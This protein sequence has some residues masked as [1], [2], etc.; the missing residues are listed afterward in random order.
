MTLHWPSKTSTF[1]CLFTT[2]RWGNVDIVT[3]IAL[4][5]LWQILY[6]E[7]RMAQRYSNNIGSD[8]LFKFSLHT[9]NTLIQDWLFA[10]TVVI[11][12]RFLYKVVHVLIACGSNGLLSTWANGWLHFRWVP[13][14]IEGVVNI[15]VYDMQ[16]SLYLMEH[17]IIFSINILY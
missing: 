17:I 12:K 2:L 11:C 13:A 3:S 4:P 16:R 14:A 9:I 1:P 5:F 8:C 6:Q 15:C 10:L 7:N